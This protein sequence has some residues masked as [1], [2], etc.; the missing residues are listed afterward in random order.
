MEFD[1]EIIIVTAALVELSKRFGLGGNWLLV[2]SI[3]IGSSL[4]ALSK[5][6][7]DFYN[8]NLPILI[9]GLVASGLYE[10]V[11]KSGVGIA[12]R[13]AKILECAYGNSPRIINIGD[14][15]CNFRYVIGLC[16]CY[17]WLYS[18]ESWIH[19]RHT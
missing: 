19:I 1:N 7:T 3:V 9:A 12:E 18:L 11:T 16:Q 6:A 13:I 17:W 15:I 10:I 8:D 4:A 14:G 5:Y 2:L